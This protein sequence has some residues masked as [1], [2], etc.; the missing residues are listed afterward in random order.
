MIVSIETKTYKVDFS[1]ARIISQV[2]ES[3]ILGEGGG[4][5]MDLNFLISKYLC[6]SKQKNL[7]KNRG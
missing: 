1:C 2:C 3:I 7:T 6:A 5:G 4:R